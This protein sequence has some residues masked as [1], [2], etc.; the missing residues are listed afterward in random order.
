M[1]SLYE[2]NA[3]AFFAGYIAFKCIKDCHTC[4]V[5]MCKSPID[6]RSA[7]LAGGISGCLRRDELVSITTDMV[8]DTSEELIINIPTTKTHVAKKFCVDG[9]FYNRTKQYIAS[10]SQFPD[11]R[12][13]FLRYEK[14]KCVN[15]VVGLHKFGE[16]PQLIAKF[17]NLPEPEIYTGHMFRRTLGTLLADAGGTITEIKRHGNWRS[18]SVAEGYVENSLYA[19]YQITIVS[20]PALTDPKETRCFHAV[21]RVCWTMC[22]NVGASSTVLKSSWGLG[23]VFPAAKVVNPCCVEMFC[24]PVFPGWVGIWFQDLW[25][26]CQC[27]CRV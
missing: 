8:K 24:C 7:I 19:K 14:G 21:A 27:E 18:V 3:I 2:A 11:S 9:E 1:T 15:Q 5:D 22:C 25:L 16:V 10:R 20:V 26:G 13:F 23:T 4:K 17:L 12:R 6:A